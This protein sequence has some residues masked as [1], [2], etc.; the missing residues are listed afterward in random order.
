MMNSPD[1]LG[2]HR[3]APRLPA[4]SSVWLQCRRAGAAEG[5]E[6]ANGLLDLSNGGL[7]F[8]SRQLLAIGEAI[9]VS[10][11]GSA[12]YGSIRRRGEVRWVVELGDGAC[13][14]GVQFDQPLTAGDVQALLPAEP[15]T[16]RAGTFLFDAV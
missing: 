4:P 2:H 6:L 11:G 8:L 16:A 5:G 1:T 14:A 12:M 13:C 15:P 10:L 7:Q 9:T 3:T